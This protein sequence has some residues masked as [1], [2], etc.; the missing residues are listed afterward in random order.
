MYQNETSHTVSHAC[1]LPKSTYPFPLKVYLCTKNEAFW[2]K[3]LFQ[4][5]IMWKMGSV[6][7]QITYRW[8][9]SPYLERPLISKN[10]WFCGS[11]QVVNFYVGTFRVHIRFLA[12]F[13]LSARTPNE[14]H[15]QIQ[16]IAEGFEKQKYFFIQ[17]VND[18]SSWKWLFF[19]T[20][21]PSTVPVRTISI[22][23][24]TNQWF[25]PNCTKFDSDCQEDKRQVF[26]WKVPALFSQVKMNI[27]QRE[28]LYLVW[29]FQ[30]LVVLSLNTSSF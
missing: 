3:K 28:I 5:A 22:Q 11:F 21:S 27:I 10:Q 13:E 26:R 7:C 24:W 17:A 19:K 20:F 6:L 14:S 25:L 23:E 29:V 8:L 18:D 16:A 1:N 4:H 9:H 30:Y 15:L 2:I 12:K